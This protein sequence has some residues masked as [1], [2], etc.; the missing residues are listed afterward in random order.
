MEPCLAWKHIRLLTKGE[1][2]H[3]EQCTAMAMH[4]PDGSCAP[5]ASENMSVLAPHFQ[6]VFNNHCSTDPT[7]LEHITQ[8]RTLCELNNLI[9]WE[10]FSKAVRK[11]KNA[12]AAG[13]TKVP[14][15]VFK[16]MTACNLRHVYKHVNDFFLS[17][18]DYDQW[19]RSQCAPVPKNDDLSDPNKG[20]GVMLMDICS[21]IFSSIMNGRAFKLLDKHGT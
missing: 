4:I 21:K 2:A 19:H 9:S 20:R 10:E 17:T 13:L 8:R 18:A 11:L 12:K 5:N 7:L 3:H 1:S 14:P 16:A 6:Q 15:K